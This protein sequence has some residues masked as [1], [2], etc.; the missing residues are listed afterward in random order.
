MRRNVP[1]A[2]IWVAA[3]AVLAPTVPPVLSLKSGFPAAPRVLAIHWSGMLMPSNISMFPRMTAST[4]AMASP[5]CSRQRSTAS[6]ASSAT[7]T[8]SRRDTW[9]VW[10][11]A[12]IATRRAISPP[13]GSRGLEAHDVVAL[14]EDARAAV[15][16]RPA[17][18]LAQRSPPPGH[19]RQAGDD[20]GGAAEPAPPRRALAGQVLDDPLGIPEPHGPAPHQRLV[21]EGRRQLDDAGQPVP[22]RGAEGGVARG[23]QRGDGGQVAI[24]PVRVGRR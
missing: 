2:S 10:P 3:T 14:A 6:R 5:A 1:A 23:R 12:T 20:A 7:F 11:A 13:D 24:G 22:P 21:G 19:G 15:G 17:R 9:S 18:P 16:E 8:S 4:S